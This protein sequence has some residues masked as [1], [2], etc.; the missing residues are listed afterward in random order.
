[1]MTDRLYLVKESILCDDCLNKCQTERKKL[2]DVVKRKEH[3]LLGLSNLV[4]Q[5]DREV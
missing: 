5:E 1:M 3:K 2:E 4:N